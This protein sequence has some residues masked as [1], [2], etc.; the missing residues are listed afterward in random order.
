LSCFKQAENSH[1]TIIR[2]YNPSNKPAKGDLEFDF[3]IKNA[4]KVNMNEK[5]QE[6]LKPDTHKIFL[7][8]SP[9]K[10]ETI[11]VELVP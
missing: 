6:V 7:Q 8:L 5:R 1:N 9:G 4:Y 2:V 3:K 10:I 11:E